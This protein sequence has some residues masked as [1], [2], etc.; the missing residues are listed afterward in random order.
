VREGRAVPASPPPAPPSPP[1]PPPH[2]PTRLAERPAAGAGPS[3]PPPPAPAYDGGGCGT[4][5]SLTYDAKFFATWGVARCSSCRAG[6]GF[7]TKT[8]AR[9]LYLATEADLRKLRSVEKENPRQKQWG[10]MRL[11]LRSQ[12]EQVALSRHGSARG[13]EEAR[14]AAAR[15]RA[16]ARQRKREREEAR[17]RGEAEALLE[18]RRGLE[19]DEERRR[20]ARLEEPGRLAPS[21]DTEEL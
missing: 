10:K 3:E 15:G 11:F 6:E 1:T 7:V 20:R 2:H 18:V 12:V 16:E 17:G 21:L 14:V 5:D 19:E 13:L 4:C 8:D 9:K